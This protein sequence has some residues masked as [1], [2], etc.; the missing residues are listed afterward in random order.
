VLNPFT[1]EA[2]STY[3]TAATAGVVAALAYAASAWV[4][5]HVKT[6]AVARGLL[7]RP[8]GERRKHD[9]PIPRLGGVGV[10]AGLLLAGLVALGV[11]LQGYTVSQYLRIVLAVCAGGVLLFITGIVDDVRGVRPAIKIV[12]QGCAALIVWQF[13]FRIEQLVLPASHV[14]TL[15]AF[16]F[17]VTA[18]W[19]IGLSNAFNLVDGADGLAGGVAIIALAAAGLSAVLVQDRLVIWSCLTLA[20]ALLGFLRYNMP[21]AR[22]FLG[23]S[24]SL[25]VGFLLAVLTVKGMSREDGAVYALAPVLALAYPLLDTGT[26]M[27]RR[28]LRGE[29]LSR[30]DGRHIHHQLLALGL[31][32]R[33]TLA[34]IY[35]FSS[36]VAVLGLF[37]TFAAPLV[38]ITVAAVSVLVLLLFL[39]VGAQW[40]EYH[41]LLEAGA[42]FLAV[43]RHGRASLRTKIHARDLARLIDAARTADEL[44]AVVAAGAGTFDFAHMQ[45]RRD[46]ALEA[47][48]VEIAL[49]IDRSRVWVMDYPIISST[50]YADRLFLSIWCRVD[51]IRPVGAEAVARI[52][53][54]SLQRWA[55]RQ[56]EMTALASSTYETEVMTTS[57]ESLAL[58]ARPS[59]A[60]GSAPAVQVRP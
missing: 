47:P 25:V 26:S 14:I 56:F 43:L 5:R 4:Q 60:L 48:P 46:I 34:V 31:T 15:G 39:V 30:A 41:E 24:G 22:I 59:P 2:M 9:L 52:L 20:S 19:I 37:A 21:P 6:F 17:P 45:I 49:E 8:D 40:L 36:V 12:V 27:V 23:D 58:A 51:E 35:G 50:L 13:G 57:G 16:A 32:P 44:S 1:G 11:E 7:D 54:P 33:Q 18:I 29:P 10:F 28:W 3:L 53:V 38:T 55:E 42:S